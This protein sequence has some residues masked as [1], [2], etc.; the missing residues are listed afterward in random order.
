MEKNALAMLFEDIR[1]YIFANPRIVALTALNSKRL[2]FVNGNGIGHV[3]D[4]TKKSEETC[5]WEA[6]GEGW[7]IFAL[8]YGRSSLVRQTGQLDKGGYYVV[9]RT[10]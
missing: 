1:R 3:T 6:G 2:S 9:L 4:A 10:G 5:T 7:R 8:L